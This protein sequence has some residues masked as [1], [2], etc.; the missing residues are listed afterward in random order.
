MK[1]SYFHRG[2]DVP[3]LGQ[4]IAEHFLEI[5]ARFPNREAVISM[6]QQLQ[7]TY[8]QLS[9]QIDIVAKGLL[10]FGFT[11]G[12]RI[13]IW[14]TN[15]LQ[16]ILIQMA[17]ARLGIILVNINPAYRVQ[18]LEYA[19]KQSQVQCLVMIP[20]FK[21]SH[22]LDMLLELLP[23]LK[24]QQTESLNFSSFPDLR[25]IIVYNPADPVQTSVPYSSFTTWQTLISAAKNT[26][27]KQLQQ[28]TETLDTDDPINI[29]YT[30]GT[31]GFPKAV[32]L[33][34]H[35]ILN[36]AWFAALAMH[37]DEQ[38][39]LCIP[40]PFYHCFGMVIANLLC[41]SVGACAV[42]ACEHFDAEAVLKAIE[43]HHCTALHGVPTMFIAEL[44]HENF[45]HYQ[46]DSLRTGIMAGAPCSPEL[47]QRV[48]EQMHC[49]E[50]LIGYG[51]TEA[52]PLTHLTTREDSLQRRT[53][54][55]GHNLPHQEVKVI[56]TDNHQTVALGETG[57][58]CFRGYH[59]MQGYYAN[60]KATENAIDAQGWL[61]S[62][63]LGAMDKD[64]YI[65]IT[66]R[67]KDMIIRGGENIYPREIE[68]TI[69][70]HP[71]VAE[72]A[73]F[74]VPDDFYGEQLVAWIQLHHG[75]HCDEE[76][77]REFCRGKLS[78][79]KIPH[80]IRF[81][82]AFPMTVT[83]KLQKFQMQKQMIKILESLAS[84]N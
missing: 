57:E 69:F 45:K 20:A 77:V 81:V 2:G 3:L 8:A 31:T 24:H 5:A 42:I 75:V 68:D 11:K 19:L 25:R 28:T 58:V 21:N 17:T 37:F 66:G 55:V 52:S 1:K 59:I 72:V 26:S 32:V 73:V 61:H 12:D 36:N 78:H 46:L 56:N 35:N 53:Q 83:G 34:H 63:D 14:S 33:S 27:Q 7:L 79:F 29:Q 67:L 4:T 64:G 43:Q 22:Y 16:W 74:G 48:M 80:Y 51:E 9:G 10:S 30:S 60:P 84:K 6:P 41:F 23:K 70:T 71:K 15:N 62:G 54:T 49:P 39:R 82:D 76:D 65:R 50:I 47:M 40:V 44:E 18:E 13:G 38:D